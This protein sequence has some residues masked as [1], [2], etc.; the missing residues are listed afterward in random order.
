MIT[1]KARGWIYLADD[2]MRRFVAEAHTEHCPRGEDGRTVT[3]PDANDVD[4][5]L[6]HFAGGYADDANI[7]RIE[8]GEC[9]CLGFR[10]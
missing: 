7:R 2:G 6:R 5:W 3:L 10:Q 1:I 9:G 4:D 8:Y